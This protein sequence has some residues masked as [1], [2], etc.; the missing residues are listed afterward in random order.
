MGEKEIN[1][2]VGANNES[3]NHTRTCKEGVNTCAKHFE[4]ITCQ[5]ENTK[6]S[7]T[8]S[9]VRQQGVHNITCLLPDGGY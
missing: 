9:F 1:D 6:V 3:P 5:T 2:A 7:G 8:K 4:G